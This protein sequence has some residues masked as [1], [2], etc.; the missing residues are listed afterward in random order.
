MSD[1]QILYADLKGTLV[2]HIVLSGGQDRE[3]ALGTRLDLE[4]SRRLMLSVCVVKYSSYTCI[5]VHIATLLFLVISNITV[6]CSRRHA[7][8]GVYNVMHD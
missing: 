1:H 6:Q 3:R 5:H 4:S 2:H 8:A 7:G